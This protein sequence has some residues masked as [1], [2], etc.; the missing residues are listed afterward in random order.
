MNPSLSSVM[1]VFLVRL[2]LQDSSQLKKG[3]YYRMAE[4]CTV[5]CHLIWSCS[6]T[7]L[8]ILSFF[9]PSFIIIIILSCHSSHLILSF[10]FFILLIL[11]Y[12]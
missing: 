11:S 5:L 10:H 9:S 4:S 8:L 7:Y 1:E 6:S 3:H 12:H 2:H